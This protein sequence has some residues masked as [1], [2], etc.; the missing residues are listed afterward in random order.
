VGNY[1]TEA[2]NRRW[3]NAVPHVH[4]YFDHCP[5]CLGQSIHAAA[6]FACDSSPA[7]TCEWFSW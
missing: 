5:Q 3:E 6:R 2:K 7:Y 4:P 1:S